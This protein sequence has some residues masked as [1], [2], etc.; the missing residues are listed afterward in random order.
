MG[1]R[2]AL[3]A[4]QERLEK[5]TGADREIDALIAVACDPRFNG[6]VVRPPPVGFISTSN[7][8]HIACAPYYTADLN[9]VI[10]LAERRQLRWFVSWHTDGYSAEMWVKTGV[11]TEA[12]GGI[13]IGPT[14]E[15]AALK[16]LVAV[17]IAQDP[18]P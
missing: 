11:W 9:N 17:L 6:Y 5:A 10:A 1:D 18:N 16:A 13:C 3:T 12:A 2:T 4:L 7:L 8:A 14:K 15:L